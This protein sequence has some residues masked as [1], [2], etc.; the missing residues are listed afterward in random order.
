VHAV[1]EMTHH[2]V[3]SSVSSESVTLHD[4]SPHDYLTPTKVLSFAAISP[5]AFGCRFTGQC[6][7]TTPPSLSL[8]HRGR[9]VMALHDVVANQSIRPIAHIAPYVVHWA[10]TPWWQRCTR[11]PVAA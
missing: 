9:D 10:G 11:H 2:G 1:Y 8:C 7:F 6:R 4:F 5:I 3:G